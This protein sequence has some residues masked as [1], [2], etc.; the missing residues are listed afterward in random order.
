M[1]L[2]NSFCFLLSCDS[3]EIAISMLNNDIEVI[4]QLMNSVFFNFPGK[5]S[6][7]IEL[8]TKIKDIYNQISDDY[9]GLNLIRNILNMIPE[10]KIRIIEK[11]FAMIINSFFDNDKNYDSMEEKQNYIN[12]FVSRYK[13]ISFDGFNIQYLKSSLIINIKEMI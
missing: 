7:C 3:N 4:E 11:D 13:K 10:S 5:Y 8:I 9:Q 2:K 12:T 1:S 6:F